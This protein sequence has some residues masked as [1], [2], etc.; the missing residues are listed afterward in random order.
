MTFTDYLKFVVGEDWIDYFNLQ[1][2]D[3]LVEEGYYYEE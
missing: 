3:Y 1:E 2:H